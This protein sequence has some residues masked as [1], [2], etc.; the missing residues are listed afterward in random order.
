MTSALLQQFAPI[1][2]ETLDRLRNAMRTL[3]LSARAYDR[4]LKVART[5]ADL[6]GVPDIQKHHISE[7]I[8]YR[9]LDR[10]NWVE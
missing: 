2:G 4:I 7:A 9:N 3:N 1:S 8:G 10:Q 6:E 5:I